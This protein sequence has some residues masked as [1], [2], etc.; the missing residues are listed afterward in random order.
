MSLCK[1]GVPVV[2][3]TYSHMQKNDV[4]RYFRDNNCHIKC[5]SIH[6]FNIRG[7]FDKNPYQDLAEYKLIG[8]SYTEIILDEYKMMNEDTLNNVFVDL[9]RSEISFRVYGMSS[10]Y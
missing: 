2:Y 8:M 9:E 10:N 6:E 1:F 7:I 5:I 3:V 4:E